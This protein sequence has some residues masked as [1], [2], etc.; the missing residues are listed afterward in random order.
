MKQMDISE[1]Y[2]IAI[3]GSGPRGMSILERLVAR[4][5]ESNKKNIKIYFIDDGYVGCGRVWATDQS[6]YLLMNTVA[7][8]ISAFSGLWDGSEEKP[9]NGPS[10]AQWWKRN[11]DDY[12]EYGGYGPRAYYGEYLL[13]VLSIIEKSLNNSTV[14]HKVSGRVIRLDIENKKQVLTLADGNK[15]VVDKTVIATGHSINKL[16]GMSKKL[17][18]FSEIRNDIKFIQANYSVAALNLN[19]IKPREQVGII[20]MGLT[21]YDLMGELTLGRGGKFIE[22]K[23]GMLSYIPSGKEPYLF[24]GSRSG[25]PMPGRGKNQKEFDYRYCP[26]IFTEERAMEIRRKRNVHFERDV[27]P[28]IEAEVALVYFETKLRLE[29]G[30]DIAK[31]FQM[32]VI[33]EHISSVEEIKRIAKELGCMNLD[34]TNLY[35]LKNIFDGYQFD[36]IDEFNKILSELLLKDFNEAMKGNIDSPLKAS[37]DV[38]RNLRSVIRKVVDFGG[39]YPESHKDEFLRK[40]APTA[41]FL[42]AGPPAFRIAQLRALILAGII[43]VIGP[44]TKYE[45]SNEGINIYSPSVQE[46]NIIVKT[47]IDARLP[48]PNLQ[49]ENSELT[50]YLLK[51]GIYTPFINIEGNKKFETGGVN[52]SLSPYHPIGRDNSPNKDIYVIGIPTEHT[53]WFMQSGSTRPNRWIDF[54][55]DADAIAKNII[56]EVKEV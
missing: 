43:T 33:N 29:K 50:Q 15:I 18:E 56:E 40:F 51:T 19:L 32:Q 38:L 8:E 9:G 17:K 27:L 20:G 23:D 47:V 49:S 34:Y 1:E 24:I 45:V 2:Q 3:I 37:L 26:I 31:R 44:A 11:Y 6:P 22:G 21:F 55:R 5:N 52:V 12:E 13:Y 10:F 41:N 42:S 7:Q 54:M 28:F 48:I 53:R 14:L 46:S 35:K 30:K 36:S 25:M 4:I 39:L 16:S